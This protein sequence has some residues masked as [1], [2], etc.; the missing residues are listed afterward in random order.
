[1]YIGNFYVDISGISTIK[2]AIESNF[3]NIIN[4][5]RH[6]RREIQLDIRSTISNIYT[7]KTSSRVIDIFD[8]YTNWLTAANPGMLTRGNLYCMDYAIKNIPN[9]APIVEIGSFGGLSANLITYYK[10]IHGKTNK[11]ITCDKWEFEDVKPGQLIGRSSV[12]FDDLK[13]FVKESYIRNIKMFSH[14][15]LPYTVE[16][17]SDGFFQLWEKG[18]EVEDVLSRK[19]KL[20]GPISFCF[21]DGNHTYEFARKDFL[22]TDKFLAKG[23]FILFDDSA[24]VSGYHGVYKLMSEV[25][26]SGGYE[27]V[28]KNPHYLFMK[29]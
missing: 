23:G 8:E 14:E 20:G 4:Y 19:I 13:N 2:R 1:M 29:K 18:A 6:T 10:R 12:N 3:I 22:N 24:K 11:L 21:I 28:A 26:A 15:D 16:E 27:L 7:R 5:N 9:N 25:Q 17:L